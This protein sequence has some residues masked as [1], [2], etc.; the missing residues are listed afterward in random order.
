MA[1]QLD[2]RE[3]EQL[4]DLK[5]FWSRWGSA[6]TW[7]ATVVLAGFAAYNGW[8]LWQRTQGEKASGMYDELDRAVKAGDVERTTRMFGDLKDRHPKSL[9]AAQAALQAAKV[10]AEKGKTDEALV[11]LQWAA[12]NASDAALRV[13]ARLRAAALLV[14][15]KELD[16][17]L[18]QL[19][20][21][22]KPDATEFEALIADRR[23]DVMQAQG[24]KAEAIAAYQA[25]F[26]AMSEKL[27]YR[28][29][30]E[31]KLTALGAAPAES[32]AAAAS[33]AASGA[34]Q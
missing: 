14:E 25:A 22:N 5:A 28:R 21:I 11:S 32:A 31:G 6:I 16:K 15:K 10:Q 12:D 30:I 2:L 29:L 9:A 8:Q 27:E 26:K 34:A 19:D 1:T 7:T 18:A 13:V 23:G 33:G 3:Q 17:A 24:K 4:D 20:A